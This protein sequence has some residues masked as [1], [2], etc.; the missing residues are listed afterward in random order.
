MHLSVMD[1]RGNVLYDKQQLPDAPN[2]WVYYL[3]RDDY[4]IR[5]AFPKNEGHAFSWK[6]PH[7]Y[8]WF[9][10]FLFL[11]IL[12]FFIR[13]YSKYYQSIKELKFFI[14]YFSHYHRFP[15]SISFKD[16]DLRQIRYLMQNI[17]LQLQQ[18]EKQIAREREKLIDH[19]NYAEAGISFFTPDLQNIYTNSHFIQ[20]VNLLLSAVPLNISELF[21]NE[22]FADVLRFV[23]NPGGRN[24]YQTKRHSN[25]HIFQIQVVIFHDKCFEIITRDI[26]H[27]EKDRFIHSE[28]ANNI[29]HELFTPITSIRGYIETLVEHP[30]LSPKQQ[31]NYLQRTYKQVLRLS[32]ITQAT[33]MLSTATTAPESFLMEELN[34]YDLIQYLVTEV[35][36]DMIAINHTTVHVQ[37]DKT[38][39]IK[40]NRTL[41]NSIFTNLGHNAIKYAGPRCTISVHQYM[42]DDSFYYFA[43]SDN[44]PGVENRLLNRIFERFYRLSE[45]RTRDQGGS[46]LGLTIVKEAVLIHHGHIYARNRSGG[47]LELLFTLRK[48]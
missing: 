35:D 45:G 43:V 5:M 29:A 17:Y 16:K 28:I 22:P 2:R 48:H 7:L 13:I 32:E 41:L 3:T 30:N 38:S 25:N 33:V 23:Q 42:E 21:D 44:G 4:T 27:A 37:V 47:G 9:I 34:L 12:Y 26:T 46:G 10:F 18:R 39:I 1:S 15:T 31:R 20:H 14:S 11:L 24:D 19:F 36:R 8:I 6:S 40:G